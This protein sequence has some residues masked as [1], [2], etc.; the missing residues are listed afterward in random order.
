MKKMLEC[1]FAAA[2]LL[3][4]RCGTS[5][6]VAGGSGAGNPGMTASVSIIAD[7][8]DTSVTLN[9]IR[10][11]YTE[12][13]SG[14]TIPLTDDSAC[15]LSAASARVVVYRIHFMLAGSEVCDTLIDGF[16]THLSCDSESIVLAGPFL[17]DAISG[18]AD[19]LFDTLQLPAARYTGMKLIIGC[20]SDADSSVCSPVTMEGT[21]SYRDTLRT[22]FFSIPFHSMLLYKYLGQPVLVNPADT[23]LFRVTLD[24]R[25]WLAGVDIAGSLD[26][27][28]IA[29]D[30]AGNLAL[31][32]SVQ[33][34]AAAQAILDLV[35]DNLK[36]SFTG[37]RFNLSKKEQ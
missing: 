29:L 24:A 11:Q 19:S 1:I 8:A 18:T 32:S 23:A 5:P 28:L 14:R 17:F 2:I 20:V 27:G 16:G 31:D 4:C 34:R 33:P 37:A 12:A 22:F 25:G 7:T 35:G 9:K 15:V 6:E 21:F 3:A 26:S 10:A 13:A 30:S 36:A